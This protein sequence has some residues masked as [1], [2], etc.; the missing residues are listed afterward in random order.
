MTDIVQ[1]RVRTPQRSLEFRRSR[2]YHSAC[3]PNLQ[4][5]DSASLGCGWRGGWKVVDTS[6]IDNSKSYGSADDGFWRRSR[7]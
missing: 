7:R 3:V 1:I 4:S 6:F 5:C 2:P